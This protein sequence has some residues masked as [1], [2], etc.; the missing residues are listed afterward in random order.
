MTRQDIQEDLVK[1]YLSM[2]IFHYSGLCIITVARSTKRKSE[3]KEFCK[4]VCKIGK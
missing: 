1:L 3:P 2:A 4:Y